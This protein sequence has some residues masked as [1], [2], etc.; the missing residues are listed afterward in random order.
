MRTVSFGVLA[1]LIALSA[2]TPAIGCDAQS[3]ERVQWAFLDWNGQNIDIWEVVSAEPKRFV[4]P[5]GF[6]LG[7]SIEPAAQDTYAAEWQN[8]RHVPELVKVTLFDAAAVPPR[9]LTFNWAGA[10]SFQG[11]GSEGGANTVEQL[12]SP[13]ITLKLLKPV[14]ARPEQPASA[15]PAN[16]R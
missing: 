1:G 13:G 11:Y 4:L 8:R 5:S 9:K 16:A 10:N 15:V 2:P 6:Q 12:G 3:G 14:C 7:L